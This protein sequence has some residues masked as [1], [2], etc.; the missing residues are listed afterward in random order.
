[1]AGEDQTGVI[2]GAIVV[3]PKQW[4]LPRRGGR[5]T[6]PSYGLAARASGTVRFIRERV[7]EDRARGRCSPLP[8]QSKTKNRP[9]STT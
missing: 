4:K 8:W 6:V 5:D 2:L 1:M 7:K 9:V 3:A